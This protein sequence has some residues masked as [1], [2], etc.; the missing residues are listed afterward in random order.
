MRYNMN[1]MH[2]SL[3]QAALVLCATLAAS[4][5]RAV[6]FHVATAQDLQ[7]ALTLAAANGAD[8]NI[9]L[10]NGYYI[11]NFNFNSSGGHTLT[12]QA[13][14]GVTNT[15]VAIDGGGTGRDLNLANT[16]NGNFTVRGVT[17]LLNCGNAN[18]GALRI[19]GG[20]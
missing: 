12:I 16:G 10:T 2:H 5:V 7:N 14:P 6:D 17:F 18:I 20:G 13:E 8:N 3:K 15:A 11:G 9:Y 19:A 4:P 1:S